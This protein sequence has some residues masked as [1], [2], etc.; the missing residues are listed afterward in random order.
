MISMPSKNIRHLR[1]T[2]GKV[3]AKQ[4]TADRYARRRAHAQST[5]VAQLAVNEYCLLH[6]GTSYVGERARRLSLPSGELWIVPIVLTSPGYG[7]VGQVGVAA[8]DGVTGRVI[9]ATPREE[10]RAGGAQLAQEKRDDIEAAFRRARK[11]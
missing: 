2:N 7:V 4:Q 3:P 8:V 6:Y 9:G 5:D 11:A 1:K 10:V